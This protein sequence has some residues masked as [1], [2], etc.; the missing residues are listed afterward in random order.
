MGNLQLFI[1]NEE[2]NGWGGVEVID[3]MKNEERA[4]LVVAPTIG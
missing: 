1:F 4:P 3:L 2:C